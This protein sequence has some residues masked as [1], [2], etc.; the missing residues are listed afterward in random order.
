M[1]VHTVACENKNPEGFSKIPLPMRGFSPDHR[2]LRVGLNSSCSTL[3]LHIGSIGSP[4]YNHL[5]CDIEG[6]HL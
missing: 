4:L 6:K 2:H 3:L 1:T 5:V